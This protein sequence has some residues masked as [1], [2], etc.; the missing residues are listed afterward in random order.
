MPRRLPGRK[1]VVLLTTVAALTA[2]VVLPPPTT[3][4]PHETAES[5]VDTCPTKDPCTAVY[6]PANPETGEPAIYIEPAFKLSTS[7]HDDDHS[8]EHILGVATNPAVSPQTALQLESRPGSNFT[9]HINFA[10]TTLTN[11][12][13]NERVKNP[14]ISFAPFDLDGN[15]GTLNQSEAE[16][17]HTTWKRVA[18]DFAPFDINVTTRNIPSTDIDRSSA[19]DNRYGAR[20]HVVHESLTLVG[21][22]STSRGIAYVDVWTGVDTGRPGSRD[23]FTRV[24]PG[25]KAEKIGDTVSHEVGHIL[26]LNHHGNTFASYHGGNYTWSPIMGGGDAPYSVWSDGNYPESNNAGQDDIAI[27]TGPGKLPLLGPD[28]YGEENKTLTYGTRVPGFVGIAD[29]DTM[30]LPAPTSGQER[31]ITATIPFG[32]NLALNITAYD[33]TGNQV[34]TQTGMWTHLSQTQRHLDRATESMKMVV[35]ATATTITMKAAG[36]PSTSEQ[37]ALDSPTTYGIYGDYALQVGSQ[38]EGT[39]TGYGPGGYPSLSVT[40]APSQKVTITS[41]SRFTLRP[42]YK[43]SGGSSRWYTFNTVRPLPAGTYIDGVGNIRGRITTKAKRMR[44]VV[45]ISE[46]KAQETVLRTYVVSI[47][48]PKAERR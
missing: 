34:A 33:A 37:G 5:L 16:F 19:Q 27:I 36:V 39:G 3:A 45:E 9:L 2:T 4:G 32:N 26:G 18:Y 48:Q 10:G 13:W 40:G 35:P 17:I 23:G 1:A 28:P 14:A 20:I 12:F 24:A 31:I 25:V 6:I 15:P 29:T 43:V 11:T 44:I 41:G 7:T 21:S 42:W 8:E 46:R 38:K 30:K 22:T 47:K